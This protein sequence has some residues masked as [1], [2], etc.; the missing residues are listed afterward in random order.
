MEMVDL[1]GEGGLLWREGG[2]ISAGC[3]YSIT[4][5]HAF[6]LHMS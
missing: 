4:A 2:S 3:V 1:V 5:E 6:V